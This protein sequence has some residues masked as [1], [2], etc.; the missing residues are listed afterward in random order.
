MS[1]FIKNRDGVDSNPEDIFLTNGASTG[2]SHILTAC[3]RGKEDGV[4]I[5]IPQYP[6]YSATLS[7]L[8]GTQVGYYLDE[9][10]GWEAQMSELEVRARE[11]RCGE[12]E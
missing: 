1:E 3:V 2:I 10:K 5:P 9:T 4:M 8:G 7:L 12:L 11:S 6:I